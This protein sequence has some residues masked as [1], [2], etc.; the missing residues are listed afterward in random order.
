MPS[1]RNSYFYS[2]VA[3]LSE[4]EILATT[5]LYQARLHWGAGYLEGCKKTVKLVLEAHGGRRE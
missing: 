2:S 4:S 3:E 1:P 5:R